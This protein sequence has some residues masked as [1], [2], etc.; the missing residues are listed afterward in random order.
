MRA[1]VVAKPGPVTS[2]PPGPLRLTER[3]VP[4]PGPGE[5]LVRIRACGVCRTDL[6][7]AEG[8]LPPHAPEITPGHEAVGEVVAAG[9]DATRFGPGDRVGIA[10]L[11]S[12]CGACRYCRTGR[13]N[14]CPRSVYTGWDRHGGYAEYAT[15]ADAYAHPL[16]G[17]RPDA[18]VAPLLCAGIIGYRALR[19]AD[20]PPGG[21]LGIYG[22][23]GSAHIAAQ[24][25][26]REGAQV[27]VFTRSSRARQL[28][29]ELGAATVQEPSAPPPEP[30]DSAIIFA[31]AGD[32]V[33][34]ALAALG[35]GGT[36]AIAGIH[37]S[38]I[39]PLDYAAHLFQ[40]RSLRSVTANTRADAGEFLTLAERMGVHVAATEYPFDGADRALTDLA[41]GKVRGAAVLIM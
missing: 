30:L 10:W 3:E 31:P 17:K 18:E 7:L 35:R 25:A 27:H 26:A 33:P 8:D 11:A 22:Y 21:S 9:Q 5:L 39:P 12:T 36:L 37:L 2:G 13:E 20:V 15:V 32:L 19:R 24:I 40:E 14:L 6:H 41:T 29:A 34:V 16:P 38:A 4:G 28:A 1:W 23:G